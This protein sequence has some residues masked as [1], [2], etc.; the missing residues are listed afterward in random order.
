MTP[1]SEASELSKAFGGAKVDLYGGAALK[2]QLEANRAARDEPPADT[3]PDSLGDMATRAAAEVVG[4]NWEIANSAHSETT[5]LYNTMLPDTNLRPPELSTFVEA[6]VNF[7][8]LQQGFEAYRDAGME[9]ELIFA[10]VNLQLDQAKQ[11]YINLRKWQEAQV[12]LPPDDQPDPLDGRRLKFQYDGDSLYVSPDVTANWNN[13]VQQA[14]EDTPGHTVLSPDG[15]IWKLLVVPTA[16][17]AAGGLAVY[18]SHDLT[19]GRDSLSNQANLL[20]EELEDIT[21]SQAHMPI[22]SYLTLQALRVRRDAKLLD[23]NI[24]TWN[25]GTYSTLQGQ[26]QPNSVQAP[27][28]LWGALVGQV[29]VDHFVVGVVDGSLGVRL[30]VWG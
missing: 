8:K 7:A 12:P 28:A 10:P 26:G 4:P 14:T 16:D 2:A 23:N 11:L 17:K 29:H 5:R 9:P 27:A 1:S 19:R 13:L 6:G 15:S 25:A 30:P 24:W 21:P 22:A 18:T 3:P 20:N